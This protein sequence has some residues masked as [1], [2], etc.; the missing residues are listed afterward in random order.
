MIDAVPQHPL[1]PRLGDAP[2]KPDQRESADGFAQILATTGRAPSA[3]GWASVLDHGPAIM[4]APL[5]TDAS[6]LAPAEPPD[7][8]KRG[9]E[10]ASAAEQFNQDGFFG[11]ALPTTPAHGLD[12]SPSE[13]PP[14]R[15]ASEAEERAASGTIGTQAEMAPA[16]PLRSDLSPP[17]FVVQAQR[18][19][20]QYFQARSLGGVEPRP[21]TV[22]ELPETGPAHQS[23][24]RIFIRA[25]S[26]S[27]S[28]RVA[29][30]ELEQ[31]LQVSAHTDALDE[32]E[33]A[34]LHEEIAALLARHG[35]APRDIRINAPLRSP[36]QQEKPQ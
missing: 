9:E 20:R 10:G 31:G 18:P 5:A 21:A 13:L 32:G 1:S 25:S 12:V 27:S 14:P 17:P 30:H 6:V 29:L 35:I 26:G 34:R 8:A 3:R 24:R 22:S 11:S 19:P 23:A 33:R 4:P 7:A 28:I 36:L 2:A 16:V 15:L